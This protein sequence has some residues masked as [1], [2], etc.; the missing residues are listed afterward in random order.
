MVVRPSIV[1]EKQECCVGGESL[2]EHPGTCEKEAE[3]VER[4]AA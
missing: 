2:T 3:R 4:H 1:V